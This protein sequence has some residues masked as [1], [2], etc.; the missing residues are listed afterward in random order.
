[1]YADSELKYFGF[2]EYR[3][4]RNKLIALTILRQAI[5]NNKY[6]LLS[7]RRDYGLT[8]EELSFLLSIFPELRANKKPSLSNLQRIIKEI[9]AKNDHA[10]AKIL[11]EMELWVFPKW[12]SL[13]GAVSKGMFEGRPVK[14]ILW[15]SVVILIPSIKNIW[16][17]RML[18]GEEC[19]GIFGL[20]GYIT[21]FIPEAG[22]EP[23]MYSLPIDGVILERHLYETAIESPKQLSV[24]RFSEYFREHVVRIPLGEVAKNRFAMKLFS[25][26]IRKLSK[27]ILE[28]LKVVRKLRRRITLDD[29]YILSAWQG[30]MNKVLITSRKY[31]HILENE[32]HRGIPG[33]LGYEG[34][35]DKLNEL[36]IVV[37]PDIYV[38]SKRL[39]WL[40]FVAAGFSIV[41]KL[42]SGV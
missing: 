35:L 23:T 24:P 36:P 37:D 10:K 4:T 9:E 1:M 15:A 30:S 7:L 42:I 31:E 29:A 2:D 20:G 19:V 21:E 11:Q 17:Y 32:L 12:R 33:V 16:I 25:S 34:I 39:T 41:E 8:G 18:S 14:E 3:E 40:R 28:F 27:Q 13:I 6:D 38:R 26:T 5:S 22:K